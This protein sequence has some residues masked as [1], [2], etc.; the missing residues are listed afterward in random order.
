MLNYIRENHQKHYAYRL[1][2]RFNNDCY[3]LGNSKM[4]IIKTTFQ[5]VKR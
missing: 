2:D 1:H 4:E 5:K 3:G